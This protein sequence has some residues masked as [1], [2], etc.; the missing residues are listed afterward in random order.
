MAHLTPLLSPHG[1]PWAAS[2]LEGGWL[3]AE[4]GVLDL[5]TVAQSVST[6]TSRRKPD[7]V[8]PCGETA[9]GQKPIPAGD[10]PAVAE[11]S[12]A[13]AT[14]EGHPGQECAVPLPAI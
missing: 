10:A 11:R 5:I 13:Q 9:E 12:V 7:S 8:L 3:A 2:E 14:H 6:A 1:V 4:C